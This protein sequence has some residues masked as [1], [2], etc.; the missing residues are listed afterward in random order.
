[1]S[2]Y[3]YICCPKIKINILPSEFILVQMFT[4]QQR[5]KSKCKICEASWMRNDTTDSEEEKVLKK[6]TSPGSNLVN[7]KA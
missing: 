3:L 5:L 6:K 7:L 1:M 4:A 2:K